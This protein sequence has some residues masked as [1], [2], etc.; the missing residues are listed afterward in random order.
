MVR[1]SP[2][3]RGVFLFHSRLCKVPLVDRLPDSI[4]RRRHIDVI[5]AERAQR[6]RDR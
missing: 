1:L 6:M 3:G 5:D 4:G 2:S